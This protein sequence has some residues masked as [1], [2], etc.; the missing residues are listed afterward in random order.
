MFLALDTATELCSIGLFKRSSEII[1]HEKSSHAASYNTLL[2]HYFNRLNNHIRDHH[3]PLKNIKIL[4]SVGPGSYT[5]LR[6][7]ISYLKGFFDGMQSKMCMV[8]TLFSYAIGCYRLI[9]PSKKSYHIHSVIN[10]R[11]NHLYYAAIKTNEQQIEIYQPQQCLPLDQIEKLIGYHDVITG[12]GVER[13]NQEMLQ[14]QQC[15]IISL[16]EISCFSLV[17][18]YI[19]SNKAN[20]SEIVYH[21][22]ISLS[23]P[24]YQVD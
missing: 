16:E 14:D 4:Y 7:G 8:K 3:I 20:L 1:W 21:T 22:D 15:R 12:T 6:I 17:S 18:S 10:A 2:Y 19:M 5:G 13:L 24:I 9:P 23:C 11:R